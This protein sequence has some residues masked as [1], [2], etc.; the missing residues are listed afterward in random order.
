MATIHSN[1]D[2]GILLLTIDNEPRRNAF[3]HTMTASLGRIFDKAESDRVVRCVV[4]TGAGDRAFSSGHDLNELLID[5]HHAADPALNEPFYKPRTMTTPTIAAINGHAHAGGL[6]LALSCD[7]RVCEPHAEFAAPGAR[8]GLL[9]IGGQ[10]SRLPCIL[11]MG[12]AYEMLAT[13]RR[14]SAEEALRH[15]FANHVS[16]P[17]KALE[18]AMDIARSIAANSSTVVASI[19]RGLEIYAREGAEAA[20]RFEWEEGARLQGGPDADEGLRAFLEKRQPVFQ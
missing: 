14:V 6:I 19:K 10:I 12:I 13:G 16:E 20:A 3:T 2:R 4:V 5:R 9:P 17:G 8:I 15:G 11:P 7:I 18:H 1:F